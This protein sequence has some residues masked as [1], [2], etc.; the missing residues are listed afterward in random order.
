MYATYI[1]G[2]AMTSPTACGRILLLREKL[3]Q[4]GVGRF[5]PN[6]EGR[7]CVREYQTKGVEFV[8]ENQYKGK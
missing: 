4:K 8:G 7:S 2:G 1:L 3:R 5:R 6:W